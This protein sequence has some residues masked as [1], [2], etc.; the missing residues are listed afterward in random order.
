MAQLATKAQVEGRA[1]VRIHTPLSHLSKAE[2]IGLAQKLGVNFS[3]THSCYDPDEDGRPCG[4]CDSCRLRLKG[5]R[6][7]GLQD[8]LDYIHENS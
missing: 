2:I 7:A 8:P 6:E 5:F 4:L 1:R 3:L